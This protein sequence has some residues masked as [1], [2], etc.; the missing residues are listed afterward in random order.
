MIRIIMEPV[1]AI[2][3]SVIGKLTL[4]PGVNVFNPGLPNL[5]TADRVN[6]HYDITQ[7]E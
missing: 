5:V 4:K 7:I 1:P 3:R 6:I 2:L